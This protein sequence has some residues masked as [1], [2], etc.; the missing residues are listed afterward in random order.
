MRRKPALWHRRVWAIRFGA[1]HHDFFPGSRNRLLGNPD[2]PVRKELFETR[3]EAAR[4]LRA[5]KADEGLRADGIY[6]W[7]GAAVVPV[8]VTVEEQLR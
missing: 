8:V 6:Y 4:Y 1:Y 7:R 3:R 2:G 5:K